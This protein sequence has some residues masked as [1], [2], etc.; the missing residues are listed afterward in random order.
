V[1]AVARKD[2]NPGQ[3]ETAA[4]RRVRALGL[5]RQ[6]CTYEAIGRRLGVNEATA[7]RDVARALAD[8]KGLETAEAEGLRRLELERLDW[9][10]R[11]LRP[12]L[13]QGDPQAVNSAIRLSERRARLLGLDLQPAF[14][15]AGSSVTVIGGVDIAVILGQKPGIGRESIRPPG[16]PAPPRAVDTAPALPVLTGFAGGGPVSSNGGSPPPGVAEPPATPTSSLGAG[17][18]SSEETGCAGLGAG[19]PAGG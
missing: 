8:L 7:Y 1:Q 19:P 14:G 18:T 9:L 16:P 11:K 13:D 10:L 5:R 6:G 17:P 2:A 3:R 4:D 12:R 15:G